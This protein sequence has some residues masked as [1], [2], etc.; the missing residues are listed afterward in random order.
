MTTKRITVLGDG[1]MATVCAMLLDSK[2]HRVTMWG[3]FAEHI[4]KMIQSRDNSRY[5]PGALAED[6]YVAQPLK[7]R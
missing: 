5:L 6:W 2:G 1:A 4:D 3:P 7:R